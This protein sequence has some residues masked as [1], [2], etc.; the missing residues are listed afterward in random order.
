MEITP[1]LLKRVVHLLRT[2]GKIYFKEKLVKSQSGTTTI[3]ELIGSEI[4]EKY[5]ET[6]K[7]SK[8][9]IKNY[10]T[11][12]NRKVK[13]VSINP[14]VFSTAIQFFEDIFKSELITTDIKNRI[15]ELIRDVKPYLEEVNDS[16][17]DNEMSDTVPEDLLGVYKGYFIRPYIESHVPHIAAL[18]LYIQSDRLVHVKSTKEIEY[19]PGENVYK[20]ERN[21]LV[22]KFTGTNK[23]PTH[24]FQFNLLYDVKSFSQI[25]LL[26]G[27]YGGIDP[28]D[29]IPICGKVIFEKI[30]HK[31]D[32][33]DFVYATAKTNIKDFV[34]YNSI[35][36]LFIHKETVFN[37]LK[38]NDYIEDIR[39]FRHFSIEKNHDLGTSNIAG[40]YSIFSL[41]SSEFDINIGVL[42][43]DRLGNVEIEGSNECLYHGFA[44]IFGQGIL[45]I[46][47]HQK[48]ER[49]SNPTDCFFNYLIKVTWGHRDNE[50]DFYHGIR[51]IVITTDGISKP[52]AARI[53]IY[54]EERKIKFERI[55]VLPYY[56]ERNRGN[57]KLIMKSNK[58]ISKYS[59]DLKFV[60]KIIKYLLGEANNL[61]IAKGVKSK[62]FSKIEDF[63]LVYFNAAMNYAN[64]GE[65]SMA[66]FNFEKAVL[67]GFY[68]KK[69]LEIRN[70]EFKKVTPIGRP[71]VKLFK[72]KKMR[73]VE[74]F[75]FEDSE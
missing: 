65:K 61:I 8:S 42:K 37:F 57:K 21:I 58:E 6:G 22:C 2:T 32:N 69:Y 13:V 7:F 70:S 52:S 46:N 4:E 18:V 43:I 55:N 27:S 41:D 24:I 9:T 40:T 29:T 63:A 56:W 68:G 73:G 38:G 1:K 60:S 53:I 74:Y 62:E 28:S 12:S 17:E 15:S 71:I 3:D 19:N 34:D 51:T 59:G 54:K 26:K 50:H 72:V 44:K 48:T 39:F 23:S 64:K 47:I 66:K 36:E 31:G 25:P 5:K 30:T 35:A 45:A 20:K 10:N 67:H 14:N 75:Y 49:G 11:D 16:S 33:L